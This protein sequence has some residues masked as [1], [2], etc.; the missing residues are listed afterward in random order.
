MYLR[1]KRFIFVCFLCF[2]CA[3]GFAQRNDYRAEVGLLGGVAYYMGDANLVPFSGSSVNYGA[4]F[5]YRFTTRLA[6]RTELSQAA[7]RGRSGE[8]A[9]NHPVNMLD[10]CGEFNFFD[11]EK[12][13]HKRFS[14]MFSPYV[15]IGVGAM[16]YMYE[17]RQEFGVSIPFG[18]GMKV[19]LGGRFNL[20]A[21]FSNRLL[22]KDDLEGLKALNNPYGLNGSNFL[23][24]DLFS[25]LTVGVTFDIWKDDCDCHQF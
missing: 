22:L 16:N 18:V 6:A 9:F 21:Q 14:K 19:K 24:N 15:F 11:L 23:K 5:R 10:V 12:N 8:A 17:N 13:E 3:H 20:N 7:I 1:A 2:L 25:T 4:L